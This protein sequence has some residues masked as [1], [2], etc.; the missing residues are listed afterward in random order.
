M[1][2]CTEYTLDRIQLNRRGWGREGEKKCM[3][4]NS[5]SNRFP[6]KVDRNNLNTT[7]SSELVTSLERIEISS[8]HFPLS[9]SLPLFN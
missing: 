4:K 8:Q 5:I 3:W 7:S 9:L 2:A 1:V 6:I